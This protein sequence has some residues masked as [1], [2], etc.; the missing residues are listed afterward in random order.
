[1]ATR[2]M[3]CTQKRW[4]S[5]ALLLPSAFMAVA[6][7]A[8]GFTDRWVF[9]ARAIVD[10]KDVAFVTNVVAK[11]ASFGFNGMMLAGMDDV[12]IWPEWRKSRLRAVR[13]F[14]E[15]NGVEPIPMIWSVGY[16]TM[17]NRDP[18]LAEGLEVSS[19]PYVRCGDKA[20]FDKA[21]AAEVLCG[22]G[23]F[24]NISRKGG[25]EI[26]AGWD[27]W[28][29]VGEVVAV[30]SEVFRSGNRSMRLSAFDR[31]SDGQAR[32]LRKS[33][34]L[35]PGR[36]YA[37]TGW[38]KATDDFSPRSSLRV[39]ASLDGEFFAMTSVLDGVRTNRWSKFSV[40]LVIGKAGDVNLYVGTWGAKTGAVWVDDVRVEEVGICGVLRRGGCP[41]AVRSEQSGR[42]FE[43]GRDYDPVPSVKSSVF[44]SKPESLMLTIPDGSAIKN[45]ERLL[46]GGYVPV[47]V[48]NGRQCSTCMS[49]K[50]LYRHF[51]DSAQGVKAELDP[52]TWFI[53]MDEIRM[54]GTCAA[55]RA[56]NTDMAHILGDCVTRQHR[57]IRKVSPNA[58]ICIWSDMLNPYHNAKDRFFCCQGSFKGVWRLIPHDITIVDWYG[59]KYPKSLPFWRKEG[60]DVIAATYYDAPMEKRAIPDISFAAKQ[61][62]VHG[63][64]YTTWC[65]DYTRLGSFAALLAP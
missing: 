49:E 37:V 59:A 40:P 62:N 21:A 5:A 23:D 53:S 61:P 10:D 2:T 7:A 28:D 44:S 43:E 32:L 47:T 27:A 18:S 13:R 31:S 35:K 36:Q 55:C 58:R 42:V 34:P 46:I 57:I 11:A 26:P 38:V 8:G 12:G 1:M 51:L 64:I 41:F 50:S 39:Q 48:K 24:E 4:E 56:R 22:E 9:M 25:K 30:D 29:F 6:C 19:V 54:G 16:N 60:F 63:V 17:Q 15:D 3:T 65:G 45:G 52:K 20:R 33:V 14:C